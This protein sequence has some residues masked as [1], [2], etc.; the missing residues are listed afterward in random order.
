MP[1]RCKGCCFMLFDGLIWN[2]CVIISFT[3]DSLQYNKFKENSL[4]LD[5]KLLTLDV[6][7]LMK[8]YVFKFVNVFHQKQKLLRNFFLHHYV[9]NKY[10]NVE[11]M[12]KPSILKEVAHMTEYM[13]RK[14]ISFEKKKR[15]DIE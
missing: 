2:C 1:Y 5:K 11:G 10:R 8:G 4:T 9:I 13:P 12:L 3:Q 14:E 15:R 6:S 7:S